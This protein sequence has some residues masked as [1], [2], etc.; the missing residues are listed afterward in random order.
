MNFGEDLYHDGA[1]VVCGKDTER[2]V[3]TF[4]H[5][6]EAESFCELYNEQ[7][8]KQLVSEK[9][10]GY[11]HDQWPTAYSEFYKRL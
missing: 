2:V 5:E 1:G 3:A 10:I 4:S 9:A 11:L 8:G 6:Q 7:Q